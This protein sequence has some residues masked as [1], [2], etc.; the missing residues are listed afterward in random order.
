[1]SAARKIGRG[2]SPLLAI[3]SLV[4]RL[5]LVAAIVIFWIFCS[6]DGDEFSYSSSSFEFIWP[7][8]KEKICPHMV[9][10]QN[11]WA[12]LFELARMELGFPA[13]QIPAKKVDEEAFAD[14]FPRT[15]V[16]I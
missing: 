7:N 6:P 11:V 15:T 8:V 5:L 16:S 9:P 14:M 1:M 13:D 12:T 4:R 3:P 2:R 10:N